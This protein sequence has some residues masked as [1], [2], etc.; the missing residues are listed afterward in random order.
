MYC[1]GITIGI[2]LS[3]KDSELIVGVAGAYGGAWEGM[4][5]DVDGRFQKV[6]MF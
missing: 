2:I 1:T 5:L 6:G 4:H 3:W